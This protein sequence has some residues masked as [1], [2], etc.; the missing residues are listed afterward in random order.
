MNVSL[1]FTIEQVNTILL[2]LGQRPF[3]EVAELINH[4]KVDAEKQLAPP[5]PEPT[6]E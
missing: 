2:A 4:I 3:V 6:E 1:S 5:P